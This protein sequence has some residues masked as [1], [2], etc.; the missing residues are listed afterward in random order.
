VTTVIEIADTNSVLR[1]LPLNPIYSALFK[2]L[3]TFDIENII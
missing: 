2:T 3:T 1:N